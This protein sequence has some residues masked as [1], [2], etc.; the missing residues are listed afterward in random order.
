MNGP[1]MLYSDTMGLSHDDQCA[2]SSIRETINF[3][4]TVIDKHYEKRNPGWRNH[5][6]ALKLQVKECRRDVA[7]ILREPLS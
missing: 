7:E 1:S 2:I 5:V 3:L 6:E 4:E